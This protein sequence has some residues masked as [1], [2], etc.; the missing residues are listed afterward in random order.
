MFVILYI[1]EEKC[2]E[3]AK[4]LLYL[5]SQKKIIRTHYSVLVLLSFKLPTL[6]LFWTKMETFIAI[7]C[8]E[9]NFTFS[10]SKNIY[11]YPKYFQSTQNSQK[12]WTALVSDKILL[13][14]SQTVALLVLVPFQKSPFP[15]FRKGI[16]RKK[17]CNK[18]FCETMFLNCS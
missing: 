5:K 17:T 9:I 6:S 7:T 12:R 3:T 16:F 15:E 1:L 11:Q 10:A 8:V 4:K 14:W 2:W 13:K 18:V